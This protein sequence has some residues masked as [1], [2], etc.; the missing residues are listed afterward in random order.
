MAARNGR[1]AVL[2]LTTRFRLPHE[3]MA[4]LE[5]LSRWL[6]IRSSVYCLVFGGL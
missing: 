1:R 2:S 4:E 6:S 5:Y 3:G